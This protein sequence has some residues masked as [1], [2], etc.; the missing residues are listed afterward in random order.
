ME[1]TTVRCGNS[2]Y[3]GTMLIKSNV[4]R[5]CRHHETTIFDEIIR[6]SNSLRNLLVSP[7][8]ITLILEVC[9]FLQ[10]FEKK[11]GNNAIFSNIFFKVFSE[12][13][14]KLWKIVKRSGI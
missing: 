5:I 12:F 4:K 6:S 9:N 7:V 14:L 2:N 13:T 3:G 11:I 1:M 10:D 8:Q